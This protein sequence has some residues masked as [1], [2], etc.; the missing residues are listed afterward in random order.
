[1]ITN[2]TN[3]PGITIIQKVIVN[4]KDAVPET[5]SHVTTQTTPDTAWKIQGTTEELKP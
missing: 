5:E 4:S 3:N 1:M 2:P